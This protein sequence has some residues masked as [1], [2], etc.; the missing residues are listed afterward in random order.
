MTLSKFV[1]MDLE[2]TGVS[3]AAGD[4]IIQI[5]YVVLENGEKVKTF[6]SFINGADQIPEFV[7]QLTGISLEDLEGAPAFQDIVPEVLTDL[8]DACF[9]AHNADF[10][11]PFLNEALEEAGYLPFEGPVVDTVELSRIFFP[12]EDSFRLGELS[13]S[14]GITH[15]NPHQADSD[16]EAAADLWLRIHTKLQQLPS[17]ALKHLLSLATS[18][19]SDMYPLVAEA[20]EKAAETEHNG[21]ETYR[22]IAVKKPA[23]SPRG[24]RSEPV[25]LE[26]VLS[27]FKQSKKMEAVFPGY[28][29]RSGQAEMMTFTDTIFSENETGLAEAGTG[30]GKTLAYLIPA[31]LHAWN[32]KERIVV[33]TETIQLQEQILKKEVP[34]LEKLLPFKPK[35]AL[36]KGR[37]HYACLQKVERLLEN[38]LHES[39]ETM[40]ARSQLLVWLTETQTGDLEELNLAAASHLFMKEIASDPDSCS[41][42]DCP[43]FSR[44][45]YQR[46]K[47]QA[48][49]A[50]LIITNHA[51]LLTDIAYES[52]V[53]PAYRKAVID[54]AHHLSEAASRQFGISLEYADMAR[55][56]NEFAGRD[57]K[58]VLDRALEHLPERL[59]RL[60]IA[61]EDAKQ[62]YHDTFL[63]MYQYLSH[64]AG[65]SE[66]GDRA[67]TVH[68]D[69][70]WALVQDA[71]ARFRAV[72]QDI[73]DEWVFLQQEAA[74]KDLPKLTAFFQEL[75]DKLSLVEKLILQQ[76]EGYVYWLEKS[77]KGPKQSITVYSSP[78]EVDHLLADRFFR[79]KKSVLLT[80]AT[81]TVD[82]SFTYMIEELGLEDFEIRTLQVASPFRW[83]EQ[84]AIFIPEDMPLIK[85]DGEELYIEAL[86]ETVYRLSIVTQGKMMVLFTS[87]DMLRRAYRLLQ[88]MLD[89]SYL[90]IGQGVQSKSRTKLVKMF[91]Q[92]DRSILFGTSSF[93]EG[94]DIPGE[95]LSVLVMARLPFPP[96]GDPVFQAK[97]DK[98]KKSG[99]SP[100]M[101]LSLPKAVLRFKQ[102]FG[103]LIRSEKDSGFIVVMDRRIITARY[104]RKFLKSLPEE[105]AVY[106]ES[107]HDLESRA[108]DWFRKG[109]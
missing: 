42:P 88:P 97:S 79:K 90:L 77:A 61:F 68:M 87:Y 100:F 48:R 50:E 89:E 65:T 47:Q 57:Q 63:M 3:A 70:K 33:S 31:A 105:V 67:R 72:M 4:K 52:Q 44:D 5:A 73:L 35:T 94:V 104:G 74:E 18:W 6:S 25:L 32:N 30:T 107:I 45:F 39:Y 69:R 101:K 56:L 14:L 76:Q 46:A 26:D 103:R 28:V 11:L 49:E 16:A 93:W 84:A 75:E 36:L 40:L 92:F 108:A 41:S 51:L 58:G 53:I 62:E 20:Y 19:K 78:T 91:Q 8:S 7:Q 71:A 109:L 34:L 95:D 55:L 15:Q 96:P 54:E 99:D 13:A 82:K 17:A 22:G 9:A 81:M 38:Q 10:D 37:H 43:W 27:T 64:G 21:I 83:K 59:N 86:V 29:F 60:T 2:T 12:S 66:S 102:G 98:L 24:D 1:V 85:E 80:S 23:A 106:E